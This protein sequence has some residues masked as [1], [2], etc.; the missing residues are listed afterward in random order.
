[1]TTD[2]TALQ[3]PTRLSGMQINGITNYL[4]SSY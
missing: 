1:M 3:R 4:Q 2:A